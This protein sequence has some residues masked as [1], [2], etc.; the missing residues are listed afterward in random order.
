MALLVA[1]AAKAYIKPSS[2]AAEAPAVADRFDGHELHESDDFDSEQ[3]SSSLPGEMAYT[4]IDTRRAFH[5]HAPM[6]PQGDQPFDVDPSLRPRTMPFVLSG[7]PVGDGTLDPRGMP[8]A[9]LDA[10]DKHEELRPG[11]SGKRPSSPPPKREEWNW[12]DLC[13]SPQQPDAAETPETPQQQQ[14]PQQVSSSDAF[15]LARKLDADVD[16]GSHPVPKEDVKAVVKR[17]YARLLT[18]MSSSQVD[19]F[20]QML[21]AAH[22]VRSTSWNATSR[23]LRAE[24]L[25]ADVANDLLRVQER[26]E[27]ALNALKQA[28]QQLEASPG[29]P[30]AEAAEKARVDAL[31]V[32]RSLLVSEQLLL[33]NLLDHTFLWKTEVERILTNVSSVLS[34]ESFKDI[35]AIGECQGGLLGLSKASLKVVSMTTSMSKETRSKIRTL[36]ITDL[37][38]IR[39]EETK[40]RLLHAHRWNEPEVVAKL[41]IFKENAQ[42]ARVEGRKNLAKKKA[43]SWFLDVL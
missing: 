5:M 32:Y 42:A 41:A 27:E 38:K 19:G 9:W 12:M 14:P 1:L 10:M 2:K 3:P 17:R 36:H 26:Q 8:K 13:Q 29:G 24:L 11:G 16:V 7:E 39:Q 37:I 43:S 28:A 22:E 21:T 40:F 6:L 33:G 15:A 20:M 34:S 23:S 35:E 25:V 18:K 4:E 30:Q 31:A